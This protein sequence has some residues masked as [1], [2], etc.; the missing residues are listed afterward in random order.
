MFM[1]VGPFILLRRQ[2]TFSGLRSKVL[3]RPLVP[4]DTSQ[5]GSLTTGVQGDSQNGHKG[6][7]RVSPTSPSWSTT[8]SLILLSVSRTPQAQNPCLTPSKS[9][10]PR[11]VNTLVVW[12]WYVFSISFS[13]LQTKIREYRVEQIFPLRVL[14]CVVKETSQGWTSYRAGSTSTEP[15]IGSSTTCTLLV[16]LIGVKLTTVKLVCVTGLRFYASCLFYIIGPVKV[17]V[18]LLARIHRKFSPPILFRPRQTFWSS[19]PGKS[20]PICVSV[21]SPFT[22]SRSFVI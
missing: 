13:V 12:K 10:T 17:T 5:S 16:C 2:S 8:S 9:Q 22:Q 21:L 1:L 19:R 3:Y 7:V 20:F 15:V 6:P 14:S 18:R 4:L 11:G